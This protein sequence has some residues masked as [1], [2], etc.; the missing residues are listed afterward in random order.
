[1]YA[2]QLK[3]INENRERNL[4]ELNEKRQEQLMVQ[5]THRQNMQSDEAA[6]LARWQKANEL[7][8]QLMAQAQVRELHMKKSKH[9]NVDVDEEQHVCDVDDVI[10]FHPNYRQILSFSQK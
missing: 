4:R 6:M 2:Y 10:L 3:Q 7:R 8:M 9:E 5:Q 1:M